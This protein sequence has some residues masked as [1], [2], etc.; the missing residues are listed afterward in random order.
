MQVPVPPVQ[1]QVLLVVQEVPRQLQVA[2]AVAVAVLRLRL[3]RFVCG[4]E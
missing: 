2:V 3:R 1:Q 4:A